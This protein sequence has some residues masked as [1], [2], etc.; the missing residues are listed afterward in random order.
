M[1][2]TKHIAPIKNINKTQIKQKQNNILN[3]I[4]KQS[5]TGSSRTN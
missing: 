3:G 2:Q 4:L 1:T 5:K